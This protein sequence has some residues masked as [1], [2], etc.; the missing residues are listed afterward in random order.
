MSDTTYI[1]APR[2]CGFCQQDG[3]VRQATVDGKTIFGGWGY[4][5][6]EHFKSHGVGLGTGKGQKLIVGE[7][8]TVTEADRR[9]AA[10]R[11]FDAGDFEAFEDAVG[12]G[13]P[14]GYL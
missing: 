4:M 9:L 2:E 6:D 14:A 11:A 10:K 3:T 13:D 1:S 12:D 8:P 7:K 5:C